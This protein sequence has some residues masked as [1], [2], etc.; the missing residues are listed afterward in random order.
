MARTT[1]GPQTKRRH[2]K[3]LKSAKG[4]FGGRSRLYR[5]AR[6]TVMRAMAFSTTHRRLKK[7]DF[8]TLWITRITAAVRANGLSYSKFM[9]GLKKA[10][11]L[12]DRKSLSQIAQQDPKAFQELVAVAKAN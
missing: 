1:N 5:V 3:F 9:N 7:R 4:Y 8:R 6:E 10:N 11:V 12:L 2:K